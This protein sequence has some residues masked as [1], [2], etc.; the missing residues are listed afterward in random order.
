M[1]LGSDPVDDSLQ[2]VA[3]RVLVEGQA[4]ANLVIK[5]GT[6]FFLCWRQRPRR[7][8]RQGRAV[9]MQEGLITKAFYT[10]AEGK[11]DRPRGGWQPISRLKQRLDQHMSQV[12]A[13]AEQ[14]AENAGQRH[15]NMERGR[16]LAAARAQNSCSLTCVM[17]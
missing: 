15:V 14:S 8:S 2:L 12:A 9:Q 1:D 7:P 4:D 17:H 6:R 3:G 11:D 5:T 13:K 16:V 10:R